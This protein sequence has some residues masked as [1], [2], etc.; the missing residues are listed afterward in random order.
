[1]WMFADQALRKGEKSMS[2]LK[3]LEFQLSLMRPKEGDILVVEVEQFDPGESGQL[4]ASLRKL[5]F[6]PD[7]P[8]IVVERG[9][10]L[11]QLSAKDA[12]ALIAYYRR[13]HENKRE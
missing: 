1:M 8:V 13:T 11:Y 12:Q 6:M 4:S 3:D 5:V 2:N 9:Q 10:S 7:I